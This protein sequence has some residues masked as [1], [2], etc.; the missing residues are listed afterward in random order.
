MP[1]HPAAAD[2][3]RNDG[4]LRIPVGVSGDDAKYTLG[5]SK[6]IVVTISSVLH[7]VQRRFDTV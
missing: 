4:I 7:K 2:S 5:G 1:A 6:F 3:C